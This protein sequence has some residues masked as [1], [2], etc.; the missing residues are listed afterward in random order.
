VKAYIF[1]ICKRVKLVCSPEPERFPGYVLGY[2][3]EGVYHCK[4]F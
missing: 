1:Y 3:A 4:I 2:C